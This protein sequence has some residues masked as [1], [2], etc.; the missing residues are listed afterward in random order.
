MMKFQNL[1]KKS[2]L[3]NLNRVFKN[4]NVDDF[5]FCFDNCITCINCQSLVKT[6]TVYNFENFLCFHCKTVEF[7]KNFTKT[8]LQ[9][10]EDVY[11][12]EFLKVLK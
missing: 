11:K 5:V 6:P 1:K 7:S 2:N 4:A 12:K 8:I 9:S 10:I 3:Q